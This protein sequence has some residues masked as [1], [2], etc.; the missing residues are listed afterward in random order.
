MV[1]QLSY[2]EQDLQRLSLGQLSM[3]PNTWFTG[4]LLVTQA[5]Y[6]NT[7]PKCIRTMD[8]DMASS[9]SLGL[10]VT[11]ALG[12]SAVSQ[13]GIGP[14]VAWSS[15]FRWSLVVAQTPGSHMAFDDNRC[16]RL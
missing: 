9:S 11:M 10:A 7:D 8:P 1:G 16:H 6:I 12:G 15:D 3:A 5:A 13:I 4:A 2:E 14:S